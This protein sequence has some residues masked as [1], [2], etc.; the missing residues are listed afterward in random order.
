ML[1]ETLNRGTRTPPKVQ[2]EPTPNAK[3]QE[4]LWA[5]T[6]GQPAVQTEP[7]CPL[8]VPASPFIP[9]LSPSLS[10]REKE[11]YKRAGWRRSGPHWARAHGTRERDK[12]VQGRL[13]PVLPSY[14]G[15]GPN[16]SKHTKLHHSPELACLSALGDNLHQGSWTRGGEWGVAAP[17]GWHAG[18]TLPQEGRQTSLVTIKAQ[19]PNLPGYYKN[20]PHFTLDVHKLG[21]CL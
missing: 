20:T 13:W 14:T 16:T 21:L 19:V 10:Q 12:S 18:A 8:S 7:T 6:R 17:C 5:D 4:G 11:T 9:Y 15:S 2:A 1:K 3:G